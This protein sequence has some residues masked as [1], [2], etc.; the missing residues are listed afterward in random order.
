[1]TQHQH[2][3]TKAGLVASYDIRPVNGEEYSSRMEGM[4][5]QENRESE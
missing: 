2:K 3:K 4:E 5:K 1:M